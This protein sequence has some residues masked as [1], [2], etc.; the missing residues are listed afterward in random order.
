VTTSHGG[1]VS[2][3]SGTTSK[4]GHT[5]YTSLPPASV[6]SDTTVPAPYSY[7]NS[8]G[9]RVTTT[10]VPTPSGYETVIYSTAIGSS[11]QEITYT[12]TITSGGKSTTSTHESSTATTPSGGIVT[13]ENETTSHGGTEQVTETRATVCNDVTYKTEETSRGGKSTYEYETEITPS[14]HTITDISVT[15]SRGGHTSY[16]Y[17]N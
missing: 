1:V 4:G 5:S 7:T 8:S 13:Y 6:W 16:T 11:G 2:D 12:D 17:T 14:G 3:V 9:D 15:T 10:Y